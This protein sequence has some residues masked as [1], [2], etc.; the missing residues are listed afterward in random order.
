MSRPL[1]YVV[2]DKAVKSVN[3]KIVLGERQRNPEMLSFHV[4]KL[5]TPLMSIRFYSR[6]WEELEREKD[7]S[8]FK[9]FLSFLSG[10]SRLEKLER[11]EQER[12]KSLVNS[13][14]KISG[15][16]DVVLS[17]HAV[18][19]MKGIAFDWEEIIPHVEKAIRDHFSKK[20]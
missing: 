18:N 5:V 20:E 9:R 14:F 11:V 6:E 16:T 17:S 15:I 13:I 10:R 12:L 7:S 19:I 3:L 8:I 2:D 1:L 4:N